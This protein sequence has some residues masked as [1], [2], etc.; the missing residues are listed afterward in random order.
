MDVAEEAVRQQAVAGHREEDPWLAEHHDEQYAGDPRN[1][2]EGD[3]ENGYRH[4][5]A[6]KR[7]RYPRLDRELSKPTVQTASASQVQGLTFGSYVK[8]AANTG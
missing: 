5:V 4:A 6:R 3:D 1:R 2:A 7:R 8:F